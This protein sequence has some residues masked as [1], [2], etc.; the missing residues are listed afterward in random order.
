MTEIVLESSHSNKTHKL[1]PSQTRLFLRELRRVKWMYM[2]VLLKGRPSR[3]FRPDLVVKV[4]RRGVIR[5]YEL[6]RGSILFQKSNLRQYHFPL[7]R[8]LME[9]LNE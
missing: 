3:V 1:N 4:K 7:G 9:W 6:L 8:M 2:F 5:E